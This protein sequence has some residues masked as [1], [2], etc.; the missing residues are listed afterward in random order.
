[1]DFFVFPSIMEFADLTR[2]V[3]FRLDVGNIFQGRYSEPIKLLQIAEVMPVSN[4]ECERTFSSLKSIET[5][6]RVKLSDDRAGNLLKV[7]HE[8][9]NCLG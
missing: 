5:D 2:A 4:A 8:A 9:G 7:S 1:M 6:K 3:K